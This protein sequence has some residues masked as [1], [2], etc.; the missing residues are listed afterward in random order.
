MKVVFSNFAVSFQIKRIKMKKYLLFISL[1]IAITLP[2][3]AQDG[4]SNTS[5]NKVGLEIRQTQEPHTS[6]HRRPPSLNIEVYYNEEDGVLY[7][8]Y[9]G[10]VSGEV[11]LYHNGIEIGYDSEINTSFQITLPGL[12]KIEIVGDSWIAEGYVQI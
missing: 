9:D 10:E 5:N 3:F 6:M 12:Y 1:I 4:N 11:L 8:C 2:A 7:I